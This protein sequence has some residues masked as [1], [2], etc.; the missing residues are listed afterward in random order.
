MHYNTPK[1]DL[2]VSD[3]SA[4]TKASKI[5]REYTNRPY[6]ELLEAIENSEPLFTADLVPEQFYDGI[7]AVVS[8]ISRFE[9]ENIPNT[10]F[11]NGKLETKEVVF[12]IKNKVENITVK[13]FR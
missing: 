3:I 12:E 11:I 2:V 8:M 9:E 7:K 13:D 1:I 4:K 5:V 6:R 10:I